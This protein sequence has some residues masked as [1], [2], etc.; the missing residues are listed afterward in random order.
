MGDRYDA[1]SILGRFGGLDDSDVRIQEWSPKTLINRFCS[2]EAADLTPKY[3]TIVT[4]EGILVGS[5]RCGFNGLRSDV[6]LISGFEDGYDFMGQLN[7][8][9]WRDLP[10]RGDWPYV[11]YMLWLKQAEPPA[12]C[13]YC[14]ADFNC[15]VFE[16]TE[17]LKR[18]VATLPECP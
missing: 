9:G 11:V 6:G 4:D 7:E 3:G 13:C 5:G 8:H 12:L 16:D 15:W 14:E 18:F 2:A 17:K 1:H 10:S